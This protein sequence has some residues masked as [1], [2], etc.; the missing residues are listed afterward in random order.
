MAGLYCVLIGDELLLVQCAELL[1]GRGHKVQAVVSSN[2]SIQRWAE[3]QSITTLENQGDYAS[4]LQEIDYDWLFSVANLRMVPETVWKRARV[5]AVNFHDG[6]LPARA[7]LNTPAWAILEGRS[8]HGVTWHDMAAEVDTGD[9]YVEQ[10][11]DIDADETA[12]TLNTKCF[13]AGVATF[14]ILLSGIEQGN[15]QPR[16]QNLSNRTYYKRDMRPTAA[17]TLDFTRSATELSSIVRGLDFGARYANPLATAKILNGARAY[18]VSQ[19]KPLSGQPGAQPG[20]V[21]S[22]NGDDVVVGTATDPVLV[23]A[24]FKDGDSNI[25]LASAVRSGDMLFS[26]SRDEQLSLTEAMEHVTPR[27]ARFRRALNGSVDLV[28]PQVASR[29]AG[30]STDFRSLPVAALNRASR[31]DKFALV[32]AFLSRVTSQTSFDIV[33][34]NDSILAFCERHPGYFA[35]SV[36]LHIEASLDR[37]V[38]DLAVALDAS[39]VAVD[40]RGTYPLDLARRYPDLR[41]PEL[42][43]GIVESE[44]EPDSDHTIDPCGLIFDLSAGHCAL[45]YDASRVSEKQAQSL[46]AMFNA[47]AESDGMASTPIADLPLIS[48][49]ERQRVLYDWNQTATDYDTLVCLHELI[50]RQAD[51]TPDAEALAFQGGSLTYRELDERANRLAQALASRG[52]GPEVI[53][54]LCLPR[55]LDLVVGALAIMKAGGAYVPLDPH[56][57]ADRIAFIVKDSEARLV[58]TDRDLARSP[59]LAGAETLC[60]EDAL[61]I[62]A[63]ASRLTGR[64]G[65]QDLC[66]VLYTSG[67]T[68]LPKGVMV[69][70]RNVVNFFVGMD[71]RIP[72]SKDGRNVWLAVTSLSFDISVLELFWTLA[73]GFKVVIHEAEVRQAKAQSQSATRQQNELEF[74]LFYWGNDSGAGR[75]KYRLLLEGAKFADKH[76]FDSVWTPERHFHA[77]G[78]PYPNPAVTGAAVAAVT[79]NLAIRAGSC[80]LPLH[81]PARVAEEWAVVDN[82]SN[83]RVGLAF[84]SGWMP[85]DFVLRPEN[86]PPHNKAALVRDIEVVRKLWRGEKVDY[87][88]NGIGDVG[89]L[90]QPRPVQKELPV[91]LTTAGNPETYREAARLGA[92]VLTHLLGQSIDELAEKIAIYRQTLVETGRDPN[93]YKVTLMLH[94]LVGED[95]DRVRE[96][97]RGPMKDYLRSAAALIKQYAWAFPAFKKPQGVSQPMD[98]DLQSLAPDELDAILEFAFLRYFEDSGLFGTVDD[99]MARLAQVAAIGVNDIACLIDFGISNENVLEHLTPLAEVVR[100]SREKPQA[101]HHMGFAE[102]VEKHSVTHLQC[103]PSMARMFMMADEDRAALGQVRHLLIGGEALQGTLLSELN[104]TTSATIENMYGPTETTIW[105]STCAAAPTTGVV[106]LGRPIANTQLYVLDGARQP[107]P[108]GQSGELYI[109][110]DGVARGYLNREK[111]TQERFLD[112]PFAAGRMYRTGDLA[113]FTE[114]G[115]LEFLGRAD[116]QVKIRGH[117]IELG[118]I[119]ERIGT[120]DGV[121]EAVVLAREDVPGDIRLVAYL[122]TKG[123]ELSLV[124][125]RTHLS[126]ELPD[127]MVPAHFVVMESF[128]MTPNVKVDRTK[129]PKPTSEA[130]AHTDDFVAPT[131]TVQRDISEIFGRALGIAKVGL[132][133]NFFSLGGHSL[134]AVQVHREMKAKLAPALAITDLFRFPTVAALADHIAKGNAPSEALSAAAD[135]AAAR[136]NARFERS[137]ESVRG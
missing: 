99:A 129:L 15:L 14:D 127:V 39:L 122:R 117:R 24:D 119:E 6:P 28:L 111:L 69:T 109:G 74:G 121:R 98:I 33:Y 29:E 26:L 1:L 48:P 20:L 132:N 8:Q 59:T 36:P 55:S 2:P 56:F 19:L 25:S 130:P 42:T 72:L 107:V 11:I 102:E 116:F 84:A 82:L 68:G 49:A 92:N 125:L 34:T 103:T 115:V 94:T 93:Q 32:A 27:E 97:A 112:N 106:P 95:R 58:L 128:P 105:S 54:G 53:V 135:R 51:L 5:G 90:T 77:F 71:E 114:G 96:M 9:I 76:G 40:Q 67:S 65:A 57:P 13:E 61:K 79:E 38:S 10:S 86:V 124:D 37:S 108:P 45:R 63:S 101:E 62:G 110:G 50:E 133:D 22:V 113:R 80:V 81:H 91:W 134:L 30:R 17:A 70:H 126:K 78:G 131:S 118:E 31:N 66:Y 16:R 52:V 64:S 83:G 104:A 47:M 12:L 23:N 43:C 137:F 44:N 136:R 85:E 75:D 100:L 123:G 41:V 60:I 89:V 4:A 73:R 18:T 3:G 35:A 87:A 21:I 46:V 88:L 7:G 120:F